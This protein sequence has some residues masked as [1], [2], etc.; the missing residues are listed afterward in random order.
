MKRAMKI[1]GF[2]LLMGTAATLAIPTMA[3]ARDGGPRMGGAMGAHVEMTF[4]DLD[5]DG[6]GQITEEDFAAQAEA[7][8]SDADADGDG[9]VTPEEMA[10]GIVAQ[11]NERLAGVEAEDRPSDTQVAARAEWMA[12]RLF[13]RADTDNNGTLEADEMT[14]K[15]D[16]GRLIDRFDTDDDNAWSEAEFDEMKANREARMDRHGD[17]RGGERGE[18]HGMKGGHG[19]RGEHGERGGAFFGRW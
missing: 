13:A 6:N 4:A 3:T 16:F 12:E 19:M 10:A 14:P 11:M 9:A 17:R 5:T 1:A 18:R 7:R 15:R 2:G 8:F